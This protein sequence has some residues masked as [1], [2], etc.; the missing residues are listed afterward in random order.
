M[1][2][3]VL[4]FPLILYFGYCFISDYNFLCFQ[5]TLIL[6]NNDPSPVG[7]NTRCK[8]PFSLCMHT[9]HTQEET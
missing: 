9:Q 3:F 8:L 6:S 2:V 5:T 4:C 1:F 7:H